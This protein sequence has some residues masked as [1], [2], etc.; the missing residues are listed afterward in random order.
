MMKWRLGERFSPYCQ[1]PDVDLMQSLA[2][3]ET[4]LYP[5][6]PRLQ[7]TTSLRVR[8]PR[9]TTLRFLSLDWVELRKLIEIRSRTHQV[10][11]LGE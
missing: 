7:V 5:M 1:W 2:Q 3:K 11:K 9:G 4:H 10:A 6:P 8:N